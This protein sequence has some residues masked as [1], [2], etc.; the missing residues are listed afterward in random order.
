M[1]QMRLRNSLLISTLIAGLQIVSGQQTTLT[2]GQAIQTALNNNLQLQIAKN[3]AEIAHNNNYPGN[4]GMMPQV[5]FNASDN[6]SLA[7]I[8]QKFTNGTSIERNNVF[9][10]SINANI[11]AT[12]TLYDGSKMYATKRK[13]EAGDM[14]GRNLLKAQ[15]QST[16]SNV[17]IS[18]SNIVRQKKYLE[19]LKQLI[20]LS[21]QRL[22]IVKARQIAGLAN[23]TDLYLAQ[24]DLE[25]RKQNILSQNALIANAYTDLNLLMN[26]KADS[27]YV[28]EAFTLSGKTIVKSELDSLI[29]QNPDLMLAENQVAIALQTQKEI[30]AA[31]M[32]SLR[33]TGAYNYSLQQSQAGFSLYNQSMGPQAGL[34]LSVPLFT[35][36][37]NAHNY[38]NAELNL[39][40]SQWRQ[41]QTLQNVRGSYAQA[42]QNYA[43]S[44]EQLKSDSS[45][46]ATAKEYIDLMQ[47]RFKA[48]QNTIIELKEAQRSYEEIQYRYISNQYI[49][50]LAETQ[51][52]A[53]T[54]QLVGN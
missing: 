26:I 39:Q 54:G 32:P 24:L 44:I 8:N 43:S 38:R 1:K 21:E 9:S 13:L 22:E 15:I 6:P 48:G 47:T 14:A 23:N 12:Y 11:T 41:Q 16:I 20:E 52:L 27:V 46:L 18:Y 49:A 2:L 50:K 30:A 45:A 25:T 17:I 3:D 31:R 35:G 19:V 33:L 51:L 4:A 37:I 10:N 42:W 29:K 40:S 34:L 36:S 53:L 5:N 28:I 7:N